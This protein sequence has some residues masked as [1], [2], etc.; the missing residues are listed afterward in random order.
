MT[1][2]PSAWSRRRGP[3]VDASFLPSSG[4]INPILAIVADSLRVGETIDRRL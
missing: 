3:V 4:G 2:R 1:R